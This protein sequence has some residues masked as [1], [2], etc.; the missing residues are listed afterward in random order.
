[1]CG[2]VCVYMFVY[3]LCACVF[4]H[5]FVYLFFVYACLLAFIRL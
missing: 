4:I 2:P 3:M 5:V 1:M